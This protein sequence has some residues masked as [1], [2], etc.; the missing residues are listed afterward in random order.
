MNYKEQKNNSNNTNE[1]SSEVRGD[2]PY[3][4]RPDEPQDASPNTN[5]G[6]QDSGKVWTPFDLPLDQFKSQR[7]KPHFD[8]SKI[9]SE[10]SAGA[11]GFDE[12]NLRNQEN[13]PHRNESTSEEPIEPIEPTEPNGAKQSSVK[14]E[15]AKQDEAVAEEDAAKEHAPT[16]EESDDFDIPDF[17]GS[18]LQKKMN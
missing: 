13:A 11:E 14:Q 18:I 6:D 5:T 8:R 12:R 2:P 10:G 17:V 1:G 15:A 4:K 7:P 3:Q 16:D 9:M